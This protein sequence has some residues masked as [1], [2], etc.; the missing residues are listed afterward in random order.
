MVTRPFRKADRMKLSEVRFKGS[1]EGL[2][3]GTSL[4]SLRAGPNAK[5]TNDLSYEWDLESGPE[6]VL[7]RREVAP[8]EVAMFLIPWVLVTAPPRALAEA[9][10]GKAP[11]LPAKVKGKAA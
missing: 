8:G 3:L 10:A 2:R 1:I 11:E 9:P 5:K 6:G 4:S 7:A